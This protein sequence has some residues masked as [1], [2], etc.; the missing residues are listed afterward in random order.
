MFPI[1]DETEVKVIANSNN[2]F[3]IKKIAARNQNYK[4]KNRW[5]SSTKIISNEKTRP[6]RSI[7]GSTFVICCRIK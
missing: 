7:P 6:D 3:T 4:K 2:N 1:E 5:F